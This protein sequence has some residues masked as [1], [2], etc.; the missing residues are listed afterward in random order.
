MSKPF[1]AIPRLP[2]SSLSSPKKEKKNKSKKSTSRPIPNDPYT[3][4]YK[5]HQLLKSNIFAIDLPN[6]AMIYVS[7]YDEIKKILINKDNIY[8]KGPTT[9][10]PFQSIVPLHLISL[11]NNYQHQTMRTAVLNS[12]SIKNLNDNIMPIV[13]KHAR[14]FIKQIKNN[15]PQL[16]EIII[17][18]IDKRCRAFALDVMSEALF[19]KTWNAQLDYTKENN[20]NAYSL[21]EIMYI[22]HYRILDP[23][24]VGWKSNRY[25]KGDVIQILEN[26]IN[27]EIVQHKEIM[28]NNNNNN[29]NKKLFQDDILFHLL[30]YKNMDDGKALSTIEIQNCC[31]TL[32]TMGHE[33]I[34]TALSWTIVL[35]AENKDKQ[36]V[37][38]QETIEN[39]NNSNNNIYKA[40]Y[41]MDENS[42]SKLTACFNEAIR[43]YPSVPAVTRQIISDQDT[44]ICGYEMRKGDEIVLN[45]HGMHRLNDKMNIHGEK[46]D[47]NEFCPFLR[48]NDQNP[49]LDQ[50]TLP[51]SFGKRSCIGRN[52]SYLEMK[53]LLSLLLKEF[54]YI[55]SISPTVVQPV[56]LVSLR[57]STH[58]LKFV[59][60]ESKNHHDICTNNNKSRL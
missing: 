31:M 44:T 25:D 18:D 14:I 27:K 5:V 58:A 1:S 23:N 12:I 51:F 16:L 41:M 32:L 55:E 42:F 56:V 36:K 20:I 21:S 22:L 15:S 46:T 7:D 37:C 29:S 49:V 35:L 33:N 59:W 43:M 53:V 4:F 2:V 10:I 26:K 13:V 6:N 24:D 19:G 9:I 11:P 45:I 57:P 30:T 52:L 8:G 28:N 3:P 50:V 60:K 34:A 39:T 48:F 17:S 40:S 47:V 54:E 38:K